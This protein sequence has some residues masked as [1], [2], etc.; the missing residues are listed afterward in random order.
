[1][2]LQNTKEVKKQIFIWKINAQNYAQKS[3]VKI[4]SIKG[5]LSIRKKKQ[6]EISI[7]KPIMSPSRGSIIKDQKGRCFRHLPSLKLK[8]DTFKK[9][10][11][12]KRIR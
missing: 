8:T 4:I 2:G 10:R 3:S 9:R 1:M 5:I 7:Q 6:L 12:D 11:F